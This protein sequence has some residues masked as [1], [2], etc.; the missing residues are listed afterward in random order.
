MKA[1][2][3]PMGSQRAR[4]TIEESLS[5]QE[6]PESNTPALARNHGEST[7]AKAGGHQLNIC[8]QKVLLKKHLSGKPPWP[9]QCLLIF[10]Y[11]IGGGDEHCD[12]FVQIITCSLSIPSFHPPHT[13]GLVEIDSILD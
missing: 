1:S 12:L 13:F 11:V 6:G 3:W 8:S 4:L 10:A 9:P 7:G 5:E 2:A